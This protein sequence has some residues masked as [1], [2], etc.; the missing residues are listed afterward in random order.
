VSWAELL[1]VLA[2]VVALLVAGGV[3]GVAERLRCAE[4]RLGELAARVRE[5]ELERP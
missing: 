3:R 1:A 4:E 5:L 2:D